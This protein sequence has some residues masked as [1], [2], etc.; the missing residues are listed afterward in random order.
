MIY[1][2]IN[3]FVKSLLHEHKTEPQ[4]IL[5]FM[6]LYLDFNRH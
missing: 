3:N 4:L 1:Q 6:Y 2:D 5:V